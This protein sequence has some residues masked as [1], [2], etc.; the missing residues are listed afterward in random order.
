MWSAPQGRTKN[1]FIVGYGVCYQEA[2]LGRNCTNVI[3]IPQ[4][5][6]VITGLRPYT[7]HIFVVMAATKIEGWG[8]E[9]VIYENTTT[10]GNKLETMLIGVT[11][12]LKVIWNDNLAAMFEATR[13]WFL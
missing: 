5:S 3:S 9:A 6:S 13:E 2:S 4:Q 8:P 7:E 12:E 1:G 10:A 11:I